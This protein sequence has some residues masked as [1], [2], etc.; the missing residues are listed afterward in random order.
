MMRT[1]SL[2]VAALMMMVGQN[3][4]AELGAD[5]AG[6]TSDGKSANEVSKPTLMEVVSKFESGKTTYAE[7]VSLLGEP[8]QQSLSDAGRGISYSDKKISHDAISYAPVVGVYAGKSKA[9]G[10]TAQLMFDKRDVLI[11]KF[12]W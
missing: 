1:L 11:Q 2:M 3:A 5:F 7:V 9:T 12:V 10:N 4:M 8:Q 6:A